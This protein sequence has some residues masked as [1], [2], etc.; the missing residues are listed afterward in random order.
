MYNV[1]T[2]TSN[3]TVRL[4]GGSSGNEGRVEIFYGQWGTVCDDFWD[5]NDATVVCRQLG[6]LRAVFAYRTSQFGQGT[7]PIWLD[8]IHC[9]GTESRLDQC[10]HN[11]IGVHNCIHFEDAGVQC[12]SKLC[13]IYVF[14][15]HSKY[16]YVCRIICKYYKLCYTITYR[17]TNPSSQTC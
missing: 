3:G 13:C 12:T 14:T 16:V 15:K 4:V 11:G 7:G 8:D 10:P 5:L 1:I 9:I 17:Y 2:G 6:Y